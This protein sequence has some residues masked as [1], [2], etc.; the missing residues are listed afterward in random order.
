MLG[1]IF[2]WFA[3]SLVSYMST[4]K[5][6]QLLE[7]ND[8][9]LSHLQEKTNQE[10]LREVRSSYIGSVASDVMDWRNKIAA[11]RV[12]TDPRADSLSTL[13]YSTL[14]TVAYRSPY[15]RVGDFKITIRDGG[16]SDFQPWSL[17]ERYEQL[18]QRY[19]P[20]R[21]LPKLDW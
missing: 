7:D 5:L 17:T 3:I 4:I 8:W 21:E 14:P 15:Y 2:D 9:A 20:G 11:H 1:C 13:T 16:T 10:K 18:G 19:W 12:A 6:T